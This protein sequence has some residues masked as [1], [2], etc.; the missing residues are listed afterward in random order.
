MLSYL[1]SLQL[2][3]S[4]AGKMASI[5]QKKKRLADINECRIH[6]GVENFKV[7]LG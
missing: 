6:L 7:M 2:L 1:F 4:F 5:V 3:R